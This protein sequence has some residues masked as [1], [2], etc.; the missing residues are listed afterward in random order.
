MLSSIN[1]AESMADPAYVKVPLLFGDLV[2]RVMGNVPS[3]EHKQSVITEA[4]TSDYLVISHLHLSILII[5][6]ISAVFA[7]LKVLSFCSNS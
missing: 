3:T 1:V 4:N 7:I 2:I 6:L 5:E